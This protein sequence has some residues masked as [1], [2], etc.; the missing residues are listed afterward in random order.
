VGDLDTLAS[1]TVDLQAVIPMGTQ[2]FDDV[3]QGLHP[4]DQKTTKEANPGFRYK[5][6]IQM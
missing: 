5:F 2:P 1:G 6:E 3:K 4:G